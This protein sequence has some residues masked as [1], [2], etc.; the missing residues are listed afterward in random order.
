VTTPRHQRLSEIFLEALRL[1]DGERP[2]YLDRACAG[3]AALRARVKSMLRLDDRVPEVLQQGAAFRVELEGRPAPERIGPYVLHEELGAGGMGVV[4]RAEQQEPVRRSVALKLIRPGFETRQIIARFE[5]ERQALALMSHPNI[6]HVHD[7]GVTEDGRPY[8]AMEYVDGEPITRHCDAS[9]ASVRERLEL[10]VDVCEGVQHAHQKGIIHRDLKPSNVIVAR[11]GERPLPKIID[12]GIAKAIGRAPADPG[13]T[14]SGQLFGTPSY[15]SPEQAGT[16]SDVDTRSDVYGLGALLYELLAGAPPFDFGDAGIDEVRRR[17]REV[18]PVRPSARIAGLGGAAREIAACRGLEPAGLA[19]RLR[20]DL[21]WIVVKALAKER[22][23]RY[24]SPSELAADVRRHLEHEPVAAGPPSRLYR[25]RKFVRR[26]RIGAG[27]AAALVVL[28]ASFSLA[29]QREAHRA[30]A[31]AAR[32]R[33]EARRA[34]EELRH[35]EGLSAFLIQLFE[36]AGAEHASAGCPTVCDLVDQA[37][38]NLDELESR[39]TLDARLM[40][41][42]GSLIGDEA[43]IAEGRESLRRALARLADDPATQDFLEIAGWKNTI[44]RRLDEAEMTFSHLAAVRRR[45]L[46]EDDPETLFTLAELGRVYTIQGRLEKAEAEISSTLE[47]MR[48]ALGTDHPYTLQTVGYLSMV[49]WRQRRLEDTGRLLRPVLDDMRRVLGDEHYITLSAT[50]NLARVEA[51]RGARA[52]ALALLRQALDGG[53][54]YMDHDE[55]GR[56]ML[57]LPGIRQDP[58]LAPLHGDPDFQAMV[59]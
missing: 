12:F 5:T 17:I 36:V 34:A 53:F 54:I 30:D 38:G 4:Y 24:A 18:Q 39:S 9:R 11:A 42:L 22:E 20:G 50:Y 27:F 33:E 48:A 49:Y 6:A 29:L 10:F 21:D 43:S 55:D 57:G 2:A 40:L 3:D 28:A 44:L 7:A 58:M 14:Q 25:A 31:A 1:P 37:I 23:R 52:A 47:R 41:V 59:R 46:G 13:A 51:N 16:T 35:A 15:M 26:H 32:A 56:L 19:R 8:F 45:T